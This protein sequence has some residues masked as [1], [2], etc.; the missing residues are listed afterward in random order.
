MAQTPSAQRRARVLPSVLLTAAALV[1]AA[2]LTARL[3]PPT[4]PAPD[5]APASTT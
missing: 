1:G 5:T 4:S 2:L 3:R